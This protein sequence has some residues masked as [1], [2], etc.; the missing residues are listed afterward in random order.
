[1]TKKIALLSLLLAAVFALAGCGSDE[2]E[3]ETQTATNGDRFN[4]TDVAFASGMIQ[5]HAQ[6]LAMVDTTMGR[7]LDPA[8]EELAEEILAAQAPEIETMTAWLG[9]WDEPVPETMRDHSNA[10]G[11]MEMDSD[12]PGMMSS[13]DMDELETAVDADFQ[14]MWLEMMLEHHEGAVEMAQTEQ[15]DGEFEPAMEL[16]ESIEAS[17][18]DEIEFMEGQLGS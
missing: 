10:E 2:P 3:T 5:H 14:E 18:S 16:A 9:D 17:Q 6:A 11:E 1:M 4:D 12:M 7:P 13:Q 8:V 15:D